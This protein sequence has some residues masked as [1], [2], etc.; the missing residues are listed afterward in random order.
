M[1]VTALPNR[2]GA[3]L[4]AQYR[5][6]GWWTESTL[7]ARVRATIGARP[8]AVAVVDQAGTRSRTY[9]ELG[10]DA[11]R[12]VG[13]LQS[14]GVRAGDTVSIQLPNRYE[15]AVI[16]LAAHGCGAVVNPLL[17]VYRQKELAHVFD[18]ARPRLIFTPGVYRRFDYR[19]LVQE[20]ARLADH[21]PVHVVIDDEVE[22]G[23]V[24]LREVLTRAPAPWPATA[25]APDAIAEIIF[26]SGTESVPKGVLH[27]EQTACFSMDAAYA[28]LALTPD[29]VVWMPSPVGHSTGYNYGLRFALYHGIPLVLQDTWSP[30]EAV[31][32]I[33]AQRCSYTLAA[34][35]FLQ[36]LVEECERTGIRLPSLTRFGCG[37][38]PVPPDLVVAA[39]RVGIGVLRLYGSTEGLVIT[40]NR[41]GGP[42]DRR[43]NTDG[44]PISHV[45]IRIC[46]DEGAPCPAGTMGEVLVRGPNTCQG[47]YADPERTAAAFDA[48]GWL[49]SGDLGVVDDEGYLTIVG[50]KKEIIIRGGINIAPREVE[51]LLAQSPEIERA[52]VI[53]LPDDRLGERACACVVFRPGQTLDFDTMTARLR[54]AGLAPYKLPERLEVLDALP[55][56]ASGKT[57]KHVLVARFTA[58]RPAAER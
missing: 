13:L 36:D 25:A 19:P 34:T 18:V 38:A 55:M 53:G 7:A 37:G 41:P 14:R 30:T 49:R 57:Q 46:D 8:D 52:V 15:T 16:A 24:Q 56:T 51:D 32:L 9:R 27:T 2:P 6:S 40:W 23:D 47:F 5:R 28:D 45:E 48:E 4:H 12:V 33:S 10:E 42:R 1:A 39:E 11:R 44:P 43:R 29:D 22:G 3:E 31:S 17:P 20:A 21:S 26:T 58:P 54:A 50:R 35:T